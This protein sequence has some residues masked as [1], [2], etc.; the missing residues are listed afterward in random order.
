MTVQQEARPAVNAQRKVTTTVLT[1]R[2]PASAY[3]IVG[4][5]NHS[6]ER[7]HALLRHDNVGPT[8]RAH[9]VRNSGNVALWR[10]GEILRWLGCPHYV[11]VNHAM[12]TVR[13]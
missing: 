1:V 13:I 5:T 6:A 8:N 7:Y 12:F 10:A 9:S 2:L 11:E 4:P 3:Y